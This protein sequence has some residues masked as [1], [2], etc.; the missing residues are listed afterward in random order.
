MAILKSRG[1]VAATIFVILS[2]ASI[3]LLF[4]CLRRFE[5]AAPPGCRTMGRRSA[6][7][8]ILFA[9]PMSVSA[10]AVHN[11]QADA[12]SKALVLVSYAGL[13]TGVSLFLGT[14]NERRRP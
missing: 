4:Y 8:I 5:T 14:F 2:Y 3:I 7:G 11:V 6:L 9:I 12:V 10:L 1:D 13:L